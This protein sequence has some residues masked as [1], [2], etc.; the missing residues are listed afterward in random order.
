MREVN[1]MA[2][3]Q[4][5]MRYVIGPKGHKEAVIV[6]I[7]DYE[8]LLE[9]LDDLRTLEQGKNSKISSS[10]EFRRRLVKSGKISR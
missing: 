2:Q 1:D 3:A 5:K 6:S 8:E 4:A 9:E 10:D 7:A